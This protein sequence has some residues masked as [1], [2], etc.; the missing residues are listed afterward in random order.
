M[1][2]CGLGPVT[3]IRPVLLKPANCPQSGRVLRE[4]EGRVPRLKIQTS[5]LYQKRRS[6]SGLA[7]SPIKGPASRKTSETDTRHRTSS[8]EYGKE[9]HWGL[10]S[11]ANK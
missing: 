8:F 5:A 11:E 4:G 2:V 1:G 10:K 7:I 6:N 9:K 3:P